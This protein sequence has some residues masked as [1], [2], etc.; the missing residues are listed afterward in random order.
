MN[1]DLLHFQHWR[2]EGPRKP[3]YQQKEGLFSA[4]N[5]VLR[6]TLVTNTGVHH[7]CDMR[8]SYRAYTTLF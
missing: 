7:L 8:D 3:P 5:E 2:S 6:H 1:F 4:R